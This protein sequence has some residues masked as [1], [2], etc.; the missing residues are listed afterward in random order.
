MDGLNFRMSALNIVPDDPVEMQGLSSE[1]LT[2]GQ[3]KNMVS[4]Q[5]KMK[6]QQYAMRYEDEDSVFDELEEFLSYQEVQQL[7]YNLNAWE[8]SFRGGAW[9]HSR[10]RLEPCES[11][12]FGR[13]GHS[14]S[15]CETCAHRS[16]A[17][18]LGAQGC[19]S[20]P[21]KHSQT[22]LYYPRCEDQ[23][24]PRA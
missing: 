3:L 17:G 19:R 8:G 23:S 13:M 1:S 24:R 5:V 18:K 22:S 10:D 16:I 14:A 20:S 21:C 15:C 2:L 7:S 6:T 9:P 4:P 11:L 12:L